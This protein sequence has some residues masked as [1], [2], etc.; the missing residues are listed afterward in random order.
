MSLCGRVNHHLVLASKSKGQKIGFTACF[1]SVKGK[2]KY[3]TS[4]LTPLTSVKQ[5]QM[6]NTTLTSPLTGVKDEVKCVNALL[7]L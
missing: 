1:T 6:G 2:V 5:S 3:I 7:F 4:L